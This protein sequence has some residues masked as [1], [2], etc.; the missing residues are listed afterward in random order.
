MNGTGRRCV[1]VFATFGAGGPQIRATQLLAHLGPDFCHVVLAMDGRTEAKAQLPPGIDVQFAEPPPRGGFLATMRTLRRRLRELQPDLVLTYNW[2]AIEAAAAAVRERLPLVHHE[3]GFGPD[4]AQ[5]R[6]RRRNWIRRLVLRRTPVI[7]PSAVLQRI[8]LHEWKLRPQRVHLL[9]N[10][11]DLRRFAPGPAVTA[12]VVG[13]IGGLRPEKD[14]DNL[15]TA[16]ARLGADVRV[17]IVGG[18]ALLE[19]LRQRAQA[20]GLGERVTFVGPVRDTAPHYHELAVFVLSSRTE[21]MPIAMLEAMASGLP[22]VATDVGDVRGMLPGS[23]TA[24]VVPKEDPAAL[25]AAL[26]PLLTDA[27]LRA[28][29][30]ADNRAVAEQ[31]YELASCYERFAAVYRAACRSPRS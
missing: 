5:Q 19:P 22:V 16:V 27:A 8:A 10:G 29:L 28:R 1:H 31:R 25:A 9:P 18:G 11:V 6:A 20:L 24:C 14:H 13:T 15:L 23:A 4:E 7:V 3:D 12:P 17:R 2:G 30:G 26:R 21:Q